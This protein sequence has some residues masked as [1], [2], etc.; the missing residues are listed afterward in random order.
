MPRSSPRFH[1]AA[2]LVAVAFFA[3]GA[4]AAVQLEACDDLSSIPVN[5]NV[6][7]ATQVQPIFGGCVSCHNSGDATADLNLEAGV[8]PAS[9]NYV[10]SAQ[11]ASVIRVV[12]AEPDASLLFHK[13][14]CEVQDVGF[15]R[16][17][18]G[19]EL[20]LAE[21][22][23]IHDWIEQ[24][25]RAFLDGDPLSDVLFRDGFESERLP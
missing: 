19:G 21:Q 17:P 23:M 4:R 5:V 20:T 1:P 14:N 13:V 3:T 16:M 12:P 25:A 9:L 18:V 2:A 11:N 8:A 7:Y 22:A 6:D 24:G 15:F 10:P